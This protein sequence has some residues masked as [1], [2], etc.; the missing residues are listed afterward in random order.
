MKAFLRAFVALVLVFAM[1][2]FVGVFRISTR[3]I[4]SRAQP[5]YVETVVARSL[6]HLA[7]PRSAREQKNPVERT[8]DV[9]AE[10]MAHFADHCAGCHANNG[11]GDTEIGRGLYPKPPD[12]RLNDT[13]SLSD[14]ELFYIIENGVRFT[15]MPAWS[16]GD[17]EGG[18]G[19]WHLV[20]FIRELPHLTSEQIDQMKKL[21]PQSPDDIR[22]EQ[23]HQNVPH[24][25]SDATKPHQSPHKHQH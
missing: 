11:S 4:S 16:T 10:G 24:S 19:T 9:V 12:M 23:E 15:G 13:Q 21:N 25:D 3:G 17:E 6:R 14:G 8:P 18:H 7:I 22:E 5:G 1:V 2:A 20:H